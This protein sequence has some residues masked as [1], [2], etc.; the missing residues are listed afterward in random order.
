MKTPEDCDKVN[1]GDD[2]N[3]ITEYE[4]YSKAQRT[5]K[6]LM[7]AAM[8]LMKDQ[9]YY[10]TTIRDICK[11]AGVSVGTFYTYFPS[12]QDIFAD[13]FNA[14]DE[15]FSTVVA[16]EVKGKN[17]TEKIVDYFRYYAKLN[18]DS[19]IEVM[20]VVYNSENTWFV[21]ARPMHDVLIELVRE[22]QENGELLE[23]TTPR[24]VAFFLYTIARGCCYN[25]CIRDGHYNLE[26]QMTD[27]IR[28]ALISYKA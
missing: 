27:F 22:G 15:Y 9:G 8:S 7:D 1:F 14:A 25:W 23:A 10:A 13:L 5:R 24:D 17:I 2:F 21:Q 4:K 11:K 12:K 16:K 3:M 26:A 28:R 18:I 20:K 6:N 19:G